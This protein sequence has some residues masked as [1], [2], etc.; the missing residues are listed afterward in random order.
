MRKALVGLL[1]LAGLLAAPF[2][3]I[4]DAGNKGDGN[5]CPGR[6]N[7]CGGGGG[8]GGG[9]TGDVEDACDNQ[10]DGTVVI[11]GICLDFDVVVTVNP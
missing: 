1:M 5:F 8:G 10:L 7:T 6:N 4:A 11:G 3:G 9:N 2:S